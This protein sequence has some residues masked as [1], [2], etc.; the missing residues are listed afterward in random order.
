MTLSREVNLT[1][2]TKANAGVIEAGVE[3]VCNH[4]YFKTDVSVTLTID[5]TIPLN[6]TFSA[7]KTAVKNEIRNVSDAIGDWIDDTG[8]ATWDTMTAVL[9]FNETTSAADVEF[10]ILD[11]DF[12][13]D[14]PA[15]ILPKTNL[16]IGFDDFEVYIDMGLKLS[17]GVTYTIPLLPP[18]AH[19]LGI[20]KSSDLF[21]GAILALELILSSKGDVDLSAGIHIALDNNVSMELELFGRNLTNSNLYVIHTMTLYYEY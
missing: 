13:I 10:P 2:E 15:G 1:K 14:L 4:C 16:Q 3:I 8:S 21:I 12:N 20:G 11:I 5:S 9:D 17:A 6:Q 7:F 19:A 18:Q